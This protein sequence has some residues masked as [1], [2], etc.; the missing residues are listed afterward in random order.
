[1][2]LAPAIA[3][4]AA[5]TIRV[6]PSFEVYPVGGSANPTL[7]AF[8]AS[9]G[10]VPRNSEVSF[11]AQLSDISGVDTAEVLVKRGSAE[12]DSIPLW[13]DGQHN[14]GTEYDGTFAA[15]WN[16]GDLADGTYTFVIRSADLLGNQG[17][18]DEQPGIRVD[19]TM[20]NVDADCG[21]G[22]QCCSGSCMAPSCS[23]TNLCQNFACTI[24]TCNVSRCPRTCEYTPVT[25]C[26]SGDNCCPTGCTYA[27]DHDCTD[28]TAPT[29]T[30]VAPPPPP[31]DPFDIGDI[32]SYAVTVNATDPESGIQQV[33]F[34]LDYSNL[35][36][37]ATVPSGGNNYSIVFPLDGLNGTHYFT[38]RASNNDSH[39]LSTS[40]TRTVNIQRS[41]G[42]PTA[43][44][45]SP[46]AKTTIKGTVN[47]T[48]HATDDGNV[49]E[50]HLYD[51]VAGE[52]GFEKLATPGKDVNVTIPWD[53]GKYADGTARIIYAIA[54]D[55]SS[56]ARTGF[57][58]NV[59]DLMPDNQGPVTDFTK[60]FLDG[61][62]ISGNIVGGG[63]NAPYPSH[64]NGTVTIA[65]NAV[66][67]GSGISA[68][69]FLK[70]GVS[71]GKATKLPYEWTW[72]ANLDNEGAT[73]T[74]QGRA[75]DNSGNMTTT[76]T[77]VSVKV[78]HCN[79]VVGG[80]C[81]YLAGNVCCPQN[82]NVCVPKASCVMT[83][84]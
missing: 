23:S 58:P 35:I 39:H 14:D 50:V 78:M 24:A 33:E 8:S 21:A 1:M 2:V 42:D 30:F 55:N 4:A 54:Y 15:Q 3:L 32:N 56:P 44:I 63:V 34:Y 31:P 13:D 83:P 60:I 84:L 80:K 12:V 6:R 47:V 41:A 37:T 16:I 10:V 27:Q 28:T 26:V 74:W 82:P 72:D 17:T 52:I 51:T 25:S 73:V 29:L 5:G 18:S 11:T 81:D 46:V 19:S 65:V 57:S 36:G 59:G 38:A 53:T 69:E 48:I 9:P 75:Y 62:S 43:N 77:P 79:F 68:V 76:T 22:N 40:V 7:D 66:D 20:C 64:P 71:Q 67:V 45:T 61:L 70:D 49:T